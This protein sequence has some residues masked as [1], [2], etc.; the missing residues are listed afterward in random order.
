MTTE[1][2]KKT[3]HEV[4]KDLNKDEGNLSEPVT[5]IIDYGELPD[6]TP[7]QEKK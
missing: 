5:N 7:S 6:N 2:S 3:D 4:K 1:K